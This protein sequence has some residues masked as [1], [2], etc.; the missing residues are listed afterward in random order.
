MRSPRRFFRP[1]AGPALAATLVAIA[2]LA[3]CAPTSVG[4]DREAGPPSSGAYDIVPEPGRTI[5]AT[6]PSAGGAQSLAGYR[7]AVVAP[8]DPATAGALLEGTRGFAGRT[9]AELVE[10]VASAPRSEEH[11]SELQ[12]LMRI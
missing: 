3:G 9:G 4:A 7:I 8:Q 2:V 6:P 5:A 1:P 11:T 12:S 10:F